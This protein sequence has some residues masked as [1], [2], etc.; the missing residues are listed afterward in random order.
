MCQGVGAERLERNLDLCMTTNPATW[1]VPIRAY[2]NEE[3]HLCY[4]GHGILRSLLQQRGTVCLTDYIN[5]DIRSGT[6]GT[7][8][9]G[10][11]L[12]RAL[13]G[14]QKLQEHSSGKA[15]SPPPSHSHQVSKVEGRL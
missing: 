3:K 6:S 13:G 10:S 1:I 5:P 9:R 2:M 15:L 11:P 8:E 4:V 7:T 14:K 12:Y